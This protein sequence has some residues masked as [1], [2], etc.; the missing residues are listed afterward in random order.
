MDGWMEGGR[1]G[2]KQI[3]AFSIQLNL[4]KTSW[5]ESLNSNGQQYQQNEQSPLI[6]TQCTLNRGTSAYDAGYPSPD[7][8]QA[9]QCDVLKGV[10]GIPTLDC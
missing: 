7:M 6:L 8:A 5:K 10:N 4:S 3:S 2:S 9:Q 1:G